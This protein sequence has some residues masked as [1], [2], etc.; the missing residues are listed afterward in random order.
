MIASHSVSWAKAPSVRRKPSPGFRAGLGS[1]LTWT[2]TSW[3][4]A[5]PGSSSSS[6]VLPWT[7]PCS[8]L[9]MMV[10]SYRS[11]CFILG[12]RGFLRKRCS[13]GGKSLI[14]G[15]TI[16]PTPRLG[17]R[18]WRLPQAPAERTAT[19]LS[20]CGP[21]R[22]QVWLWVKT[23]RSEQIDA[24]LVVDLI[25]HCLLAQHFR[26]IVEYLARRAVGIGLAI[27]SF[28][29]A[30]ALEPDSSQPT[31]SC[32][33]KQHFGRI[34]RCARASYPFAKMRSFDV[35]LFQLVIRLHPL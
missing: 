20:D 3:P 14:S 29:E 24:A 35:V 6:M 13:I 9:V 32:F 25:P 21:Q 10:S 12:W 7:L 27:V 30:N 18:G 2:S 17:G 19:L 4:S 33:G 23:T 5:T 15:E 31:A 34:R 16:R 11:P 8:V 1:T 26:P 22:L 28:T